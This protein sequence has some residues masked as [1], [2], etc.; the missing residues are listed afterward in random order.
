MLGMCRSKKTG[1]GAGVIGARETNSP[2]T[3]VPVAKFTLKILR[4]PPPVPSQQLTIELLGSSAIDLQVPATPAST[5]G[6][7]LMSEP[8][9][10]RRLVANL[11]PPNEP[12]PSIKESLRTAD[13]AS[14]KPEYSEALTVMSGVKILMLSLTDATGAV[15]V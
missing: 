13:I 8:L 4:I 15:H 9:M 7:A 3:G 10:L 5:T 2:V 11:P 14:M 6:E 12:T 1:V